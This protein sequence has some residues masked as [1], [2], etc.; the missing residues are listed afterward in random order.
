MLFRSDL[1]SAAD[2]VGAMLM[3]HSGLVALTATPPKWL[4]S[5][6]AATGSE[7]WIALGML[8]LALGIDHVTALDRLADYADRE[9]RTVEQVA[10]DLTTGTMTTDAIRC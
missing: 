1:E 8:N 6:V 3:G 10:L 4:E 5:Q 9:D 2:V 7:V